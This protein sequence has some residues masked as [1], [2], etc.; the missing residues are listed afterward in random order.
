VLHES[1]DIPLTAVPRFANATGGMLN[2]SLVEGCDGLVY[3]MAQYG[4]ASGTGGIYRIARDGSRFE[5]VYSFPDAA[6][7]YG[8]LTVGPDGA[9]YGMEFNAGKVFRFDP[10]AVASP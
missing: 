1:D 8:G 10:P 6:Y 9:L 4:G 2:G 7:P 5:L 3:G